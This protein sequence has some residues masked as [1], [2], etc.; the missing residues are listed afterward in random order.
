MKNIIK[1]IFLS[2]FIFTS[3]F[4]AQAADSEFRK[5]NP[6]GKKYEFVRSYV[7][8]L[9]YFYTINQRWEKNPPKKKFKGDDL[10]TIRGSIEYL[11]QDNADLRIAKNY[12][13]KYLDSPNSL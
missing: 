3:F 4:N 6:D 7:S 11:V 10:K 1:F 9:N 8:A 13:V 5:N 12:M 2:V